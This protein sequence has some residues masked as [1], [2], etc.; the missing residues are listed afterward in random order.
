MF[1]IYKFRTMVN[2]AEKHTGPV[3]VTTNDPRIIPLGS[4][5]RR[6]GLDEIPQFINVLMGHMSVVGPRPERPFDVEK[7]E[8]LQGEKIACKAR[9]LWPI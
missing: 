2:D 3:D 5:L 7:H 6:F 8:V 9:T 1:H 4:L